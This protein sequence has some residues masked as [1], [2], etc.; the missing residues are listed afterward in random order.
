MQEIYV[1]MTNISPSEKNKD[2]IIKNYL[3]AL[4]VISGME[5]NDV[6]SILNIKLTAD[7][8]IFEVMYPGS[9]LSMYS[10]YAIVG[11]KLFTDSEIRQIGNFIYHFMVSFLASLK[12]NDWKSFFIENFTKD[13]GGVWLFSAMMSKGFMLAIVDANKLRPNEEKLNFNFLFAKGFNADWSD[14]LLNKAIISNSSISETYL[15]FFFDWL[16]N[17]EYQSL[18][19]RTSLVSAKVLLSRLY[20]EAGKNFLNVE[21][22][23][24]YPLI[25][26]KR[27]ATY[28]NNG[29]RLVELKVLDQS[30]LDEVMALFKDKSVCSYFTVPYVY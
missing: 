7:R 23:G 11:H 3:T 6:A 15:D 22:I 28:R 13:E 9:T 24:L 10:F 8:M 21:T 18:F 4:E 29:V 1:E 5:R 30:T 17:P 14:S 25:F 20:L 12:V 16:L 19:N 27:L 2:R 26:L